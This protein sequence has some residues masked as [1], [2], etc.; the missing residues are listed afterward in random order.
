[1]IFGAKRYLEIIMLVMWVF[2][3]SMLFFNLNKKNQIIPSQESF[4]EQEDNLAGSSY[5]VS[6]ITVL[7]PNTFD[8]VIIK[9]EKRVRILAKL[10]QKVAQDSKDK[11][12]RLLNQI[13]KPELKVYDKDEEGFYLVDIYFNQNDIRTNL[14]GWLEEN[15][16][17]Y[18]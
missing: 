18:Y 11:I 8:I 2:I 3:A 10:S 5:A 1:M 15:N 17:I 12:I 14:S 4:F 6:R 16:L 13:T 9:N 7:E